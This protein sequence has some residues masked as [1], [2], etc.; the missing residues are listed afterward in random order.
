MCKKFVLSIALCLAFALAFGMSAQATSVTLNGS[1]WISQPTGAGDAIPANVP[2]TTPDVTFTVT[3]SSSIDFDSRSGGNNS[4]FYTVG[5][6]LTNGTPA[7]TILTGSPSVLAGTL[8]N[9]IMTLTGTV[10]VTTGETFL[11][12]HDD[13]ATV[14]I[15]GSAL[16]G[17]SPGPTG[18]TLSTL[19]YTGPTLSNTSFEIIYG[20]CC[21]APAVLATN[22]PTGGGPS[23]TPEPSAF[24]LWGTGLGLLGLMLVSG[25]RKLF[26]S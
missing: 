10:N 3:T 5:S 21:G 20:E 22:L 19:T 4:A 15:N 6:F 26:V 24:L 14:L 11:F 25:R 7:A 17:I 13:G 2:G 9:T 23:L 16:P 18:P 8:D 12:E 1:L